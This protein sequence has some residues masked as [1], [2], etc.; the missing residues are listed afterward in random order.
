MV[1]MQIQVSSGLL[2][3]IVLNTTE[4]EPVYGYK[5]TQEVL[6]NINISESTLYPV[7]RRLEKNGNLSSYNKEYMGRNRKY[8]QITQSGRELL[9]KYKKAWI[10]YRKQ[11]DNALGVNKEE[12]ENEL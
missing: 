8:Y 9:E 12:T 7:L 6:K 3:A 2:E 4:K 1:D 5:I 10:E 11:I